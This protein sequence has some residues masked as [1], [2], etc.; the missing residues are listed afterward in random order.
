[1]ALATDA[2]A[3]LHLVLALPGETPERFE[4]YGY[5]LGGTAAIERAAASLGP[6]R[7][8][9]LP[10]GVRVGRPARELMGDP[11]R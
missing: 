8:H 6:G 2:C 10:I 3:A 1:V 4:L 7:D 9:D 5:S 11:R